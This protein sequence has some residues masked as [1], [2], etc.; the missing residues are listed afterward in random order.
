MNNDN[1][2]IRMDTVK[3]L[4]ELLCIDYSNSFNN[5]QTVS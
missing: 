2:R 1:T 4:Y 3:T 5:L